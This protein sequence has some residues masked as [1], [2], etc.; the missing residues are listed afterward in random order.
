[1]CQVET[2]RRPNDTLVVAN[3]HLTG[4]ADKRLPD[5]ELLRAAVFIDGLRDPASP[6][7]SAAT[8]TSACAIP[9]RSPS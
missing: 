4:S 7:C 2:H 6:F 5:A 1:M 8:S 9:V 3:A